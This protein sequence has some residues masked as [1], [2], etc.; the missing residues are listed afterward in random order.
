MAP[1]KWVTIVLAAGIG[2]AA[3]KEENCDAQHWLPEGSDYT[4]SDECV[5]YDGSL[6]PDCGEFLV[7]NVTSYYHVHEFSKLNSR[8][9]TF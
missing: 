7:N 6:I 8:S 4:G 1:F 5:P 9:F 3:A 2:V